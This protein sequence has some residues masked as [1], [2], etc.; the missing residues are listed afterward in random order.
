M[1][2]RKDYSRV[3]IL[4]AGMVLA[5]GGA[6]NA[7]AAGTASGTTISNSAVVNYDVGGVN[8]P[9]VNSN[10][11]TFVVDTKID[12]TVATTDAASVKVAPGATAQVLTFTVTNTGNATQD[13][14]LSSTASSGGTGKFGGTDNFDA[15]SVNIYVDSNGNGTY[16]SGTDT[17]TSINDL[18]ADGSVS[19]FIVATIPTGQV[20]GDIAS[21]HLVAEARDA[22]TGNAL[23]ETAGADTAGFT[24][25]SVD[26]VFADGQGS[27]TANDA[28]RDA[29][30]S[31]QDDYEVLT[32]ALTVTKSS[33]VISDPFNS[34]TN[35]KRIPGAV[36]EY[37]IQVDNAA[38]GTTATN[39][40]VSDN[41][42]TEIGNGTLAFK[43]DGYT[44]GGIE[45]TAPNINGGTALV[46]TN[47]SDADQGDY[48]VTLANTVTVTGITLNA[49]QSAT[50][51]FQ[52]TI[53]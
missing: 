52:V 34:T 23:T 19:V 20:T 11:A 35:P 49:G 16:D 1:K 7:M 26:I 31:S 33:T 2:N 30:H 18:A 15:T 38:G 12:L 50:V 4:L 48:G 41:L 25:G 3:V 8:Q 17:A 28:S 46:L 40:T 32:A 13:F 6:S 51:K 24:A 21:Y 53:Q 45:V 42:S 5:G 9:N 22:A 43:T 37:T 36:V 27:D 44:G 10:T 47:A 29:K 14:N 39:V